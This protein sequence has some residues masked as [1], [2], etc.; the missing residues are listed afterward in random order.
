MSDD[1]YKR[2]NYVVAATALVVLGVSV[3]WMARVILLLFFAAVLFSILLCSVVDWVMRHTRL[4]RVWALVS[5]IATIV[6]LTGLALWARGPSVAEQFGELASSL[7]AASRQVWSELLGQSWAVWLTSRV[8]TAGQISSGIAYLLGKMGSAFVGTASLLV[9]SIVVLFATLYLSA[10]PETYLATFLLFV[11]VEHRVRTQL[12]LRSV[13]QTLRAWLI[14]KVVSMISIGI[15]V[16]AGLWILKIPLA[17]TLGFV[18]ALMTF[19]PNLGAVVSVIPAGL[20]AFAISPEKGILTI[21]LFALAHFLEGNIITPMAEREFADLPPAL[22]LVV[23]LILSILSGGLGVALAAPLTAAG[24]S[25]LRFFN[26]ATPG[27][28]IRRRML[29]IR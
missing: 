2:T 1:F 27:Q 22:T 6:M 4:P 20:L 3:F 25:L 18:A 9:G 21:A 23:Q 24:L 26:A 28:S 17:F 10:E 16:S 11:P 19:V 12:A 14:A 13:L 29:R 5:V 7:P 8:G 15:F